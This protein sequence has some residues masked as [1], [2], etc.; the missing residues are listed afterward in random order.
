MK[1]NEV[2]IIPSQSSNNIDFSAFDGSTQFKTA[3]VERFP[4]L[5]KKINDRFL[6]SVD[7]NN[8]KIAFVV[9]DEVDDF[10]DKPTIRIVQ[11]FVVP[12]FR[13]KGVM[14]AIYNTLYNQG[15]RIISD[16]MLSGQSISVWKALKR[17]GVNVKLFD[18]QTK[19][20]EQ[21]TKPLDDYTDDENYLFVAEGEQYRS[22][23]LQ[24][25]RDPDNSLL[26]EHQIFLDPVTF[27]SS[28]HTI[29]EGFEFLNNLP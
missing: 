24:T 2:I 3:K 27:Y 26:Y 21:L 25:I 6:F 29:R 19:S 23:T 13:N 14:T 1:L 16:Y 8:E 18:R 10:T 9:A 5:Y 20:V 4:L 7:F 12:S 15:F 28:N 22:R 17:F 11:T